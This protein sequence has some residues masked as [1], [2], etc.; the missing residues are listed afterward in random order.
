VKPCRLN[1]VSPL[2]QRI[3]QCLPCV[4]NA[5][6]G[7]LRWW[8]QLNWPRSATHTVIARRQISERRGDLPGLS[9]PHR[10][11]ISVFPKCK[12]GYM[13]GHPVPLRG[14]LAIVT[15]VGA[16]C[17]GRDSVGRAMAVAGRDEPR[18]R[19]AAG[20]RTALK[21]TA[22]PCGS[23]TRCWCQACGGFSNLTGFGKTIQFA[24]D[25]DKTNSSPRRARHKP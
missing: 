6:Q 24:G 15:N 23:G 10:K 9:S 22:K 14:A 18:E 13:V 5:V 16:G 12:S 2:N 1:W 25:G 19:C 4:R 20:R 7:R 8:E 21:R 3:M 17:G 11:N